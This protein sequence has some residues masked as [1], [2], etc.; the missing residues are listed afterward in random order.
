MNKFQTLTTLNA[1]KDTTRY[2]DGQEYLHLYLHGQEG[3]HLYP[4]DQVRLHLY[5][6]DRV[7]LHLYHDSQEG[8]LLCPV[9]RVCRDTCWEPEHQCHGP[10]SRGFMERREKEMMSHVRIQTMS[11]ALL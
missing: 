2:P 1:E 6:D 5:P 8:L 10:E 3:L 7:C 4:D 9:D 11:I